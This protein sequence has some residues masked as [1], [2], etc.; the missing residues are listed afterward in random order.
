ML[1]LSLRLLGAFQ[2]EC[3]GQTLNGFATNKARALLAYLAVERDRPHHRESLSVML[4]PDQNDERARQSLRQALSHLKQALGGEDFLLITPQD[5]QL[6]PQAV[7]WTDVGEVEALMRACDQHHHRSLEGCLPCLQRLQ[8]MVP[9]YNGDFLKGFPYQNSEN[10]EEWVTLTRERLHQYAM[11]AR[12]ALANKAEQAGDLPLALQHLR[13]Q[14]RLE[15]WR[16]EAHRQ[17]MRA[18]AMLGERSRALS[19]YQAC[20]QQLMHE[21]AVGPTQETVSLYEA[22]K[23]DAI[24]RAQTLPKPSSPLTPFIGRT[25]ELEEITEKLASPDCQLLSILGMGGMGKS[26]MA[27][28]VARALSGL[29]RDGIFFVPMAVASEILSAIAAALGFVAP[30]AAARLADLLRDKQ[31]LLVLDNFEHLVDSSEILSDLI[32]AA[33][34]VQIIVTSRERLRLRE[35]WVYPLK[36]LPYPGEKDDPASQTW[37]ALAL[38]ESRARQIDSKFCMTGDCLSQVAAI[39]R[40]V[41]GQPLAVELAAS[42][43][44]ERS[45]A[46]IAASLLQSYDALSPALRNFPDRHR[47]LR[48]VFENS[49]NIL[50][51][52]EQTHLAKLT[53]FDGGFSAKAAENVA[54]A[55]PDIMT[56]LVAKSLVQHDPD[57]RFGLHASIRQF[58]AEKLEDAE[59]VFSRHAACYAD[60][61][62]KCGIATSITEMDL[63]QHER[64]NLRQAWKWSYLHASTLSFDLLMGLSLLF[65]QRGPLSEGEELFKEALESSR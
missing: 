44:G 19:Q 39:C 32:N 4:W 50:P 27:L 38:F 42:L 43:A 2:V 28:E 60:L 8:K 15:P 25:H 12:I 55:A 65:S 56:A 47:S 52:E 40:L 16:E 62:V 1:T 41:E 58:A 14:I 48:A 54:G 51:V 24:P 26:R 36:G 37:D 33:A 21:L 61:A 64:A 57:G 53:V 59:T 34:G 6:H 20:Q 30:D 63:L 18:Y 5:I 3:H 11:R 45:C 49:W 13:E 22:I 31:L 10:F 7:V 29:Y 9:L 17:A 46:E 35:E 23:R